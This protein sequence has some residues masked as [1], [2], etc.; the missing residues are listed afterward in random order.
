MKKK[1]SV[2][3]TKEDFAGL[4]KLKKYFVTDIEMSEKIGITYL[5][6]YNLRKKKTCSPDTLEKIRAAI[7]P[8]ALAETAKQTA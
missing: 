5:I 8:E 2:A 6:L 7:A 1:K 4:K 3:V